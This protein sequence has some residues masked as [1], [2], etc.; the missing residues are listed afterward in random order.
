MKIFKIK[1]KGLKLFKDDLEINFYAKQR[2]NSENSEMLTKCFAN[3]YTNNVIAFTGINASGKT[4]ILKVISLVIQM[5]NNEPI[6]KITSNSILDGIDLDEEIIFEIYFTY[7]NETIHKLQTVIKK[8]LDSAEDEEKYIISNETI[9]EKTTKSVKSKQGLFVFEDKHITHVREEHEIYLS[10]DVSLIIGLNK[11]RES[12][13][14]FHDA[15]DLTD[16]NF[17]KLIVNFPIEI[18]NFFDPNI[19]YISLSSEDKKYE[20]RLKFINKEEII[21]SSPLSLNEYLSSGTIKGL[22]VFVMAMMTLKRG[23]YLVI[24]ELENHFN[25]EIVATLIRFFTD[26]K[27]NSSGATLIFSTHYVELLDEFERND[28]VYVVKN[29]GGI[30]TNDLAEFLDRNDLKKSEVFQ[31]DYLGNTTPKYEQYMKLKNKIIDSNNGGK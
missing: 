8:S 15:L 22:N 13:I 5:L 1:A 9:W 7:D 23:G 10:E 21:I 24:D 20:I 29:I 26:S 6:N 25:K 28:N 16:I 19:E 17:L 12:K 11:K 31:S 30:F 4:S 18:V 27:T 2:V 3:I 14:Y